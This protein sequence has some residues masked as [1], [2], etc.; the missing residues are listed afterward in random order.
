L[1]IVPPKIAE[2]EI[3]RA[4]DCS[5]FC[6]INS[7]LFLFEKNYTIFVKNVEM[8]VIGI[9]GG[10]GS[11]KTTVVNKILQQLNL[12]GVN[13]LSQDNYY[14]DNPNLTLSEREVLNYDHPKSIDFEL[15]LEH[16]KALKNHQNIEQP[17]YSFVNTFQ[18][19]RLRYSRAKKCFDCGRNFGF[20]Q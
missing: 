12:E 14:H 1:K 11:G 15:L 2:D 7:D 16:V 5:F 9:A 20:N 3:E 19:W 8:L 17:I 10:T 13:V 6:A 18:N 4:A